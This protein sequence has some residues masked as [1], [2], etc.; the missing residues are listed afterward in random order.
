MFDQ[1]TGRTESNSSRRG[2]NWA[3]DSK[4]GKT[5]KIVLVIVTAALMPEIW[6]ISVTRTKRMNCKRRLNVRRNKTLKI[7]VGDIAR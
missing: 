5:L 2:K 4:S 1:G 3:T 7:R 6:I